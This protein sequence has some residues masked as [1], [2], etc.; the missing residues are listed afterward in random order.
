MS[1]N[2]AGVIQPV[3]TRTGIEPG[4]VKSAAVR[5]YPHGI[6]TFGLRGW[7]IEYRRLAPVAISRI[8]MPVLISITI[9]RI[10]QGPVHAAGTTPITINQYIPKM[11]GMLQDKGE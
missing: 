5:E 11:I 1:P 4:R 10:C 3:Y 7:N 9:T 6:N 8:G 2:V